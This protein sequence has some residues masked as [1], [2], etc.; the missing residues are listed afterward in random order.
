MRAVHLLASAASGILFPFIGL[1]FQR[2]GLTGTEIGLLST[3]SAVVALLVA[4]IWGR[5]SDSVTRPRILLQ[6]A[7]VGSVLAMLILGQQTLFIWMGVI[8]AADALIS[9]GMEPLLSGLTLG[10]TQGK[11]GFGSIRLWGSLGWAVVAPIAGWLIERAGIG[12]IF[13]GYGLMTGLSVIVLFWLKTRAAKRTEAETAARPTPRQSFRDLLKDKAMVG[14]ALALVVA[15]LTNE[16]RYAFEGIYLSQL[17]APES[18]I[19]WVNTVGAIVELPAM[20]WADRLVR[21]YGAASVLKWSFLMEAASLLIVIAVPTISSI[22]MFRVAA[23]IAYSLN[24][25][26]TV[27]FIDERSPARQS[28]TRLALYTVT[29]RGLVG[30]VS[31][32]V[33]GFVFDTAGAYYH[34]VMA[35]GGSLLA[36]AALG[37]T[38][39]G[40][41]S[42]RAAESS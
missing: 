20:L 40:R 38:V 11:S 7:S 34:Y 10:V 21:R 39:S 6:A 12:T 35:F 33:S 26:S 13:W 23:G 19:G 14:L 4:P 15:W 32:P 24:V 29:I 5:W 30:L 22:F 1:F 42:Q 36:W 18:I 27:V 17:G 31:G 8:V 9:A 28:T 2:N 25:V 41:R 16:G 37:F 3:V